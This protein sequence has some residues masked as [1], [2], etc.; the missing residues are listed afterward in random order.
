MKQERVYTSPELLKPFDFG[1]PTSVARIY[2]YL[3]SYGADGL[4]WYQDVTVLSH[5]ANVA[6]FAAQIGTK[7]KVDVHKVWLMGWLR[8]IGRVSWGIAAN[9][10]LNDITDKYGNHGFLG[11]DFLIRSG[12]PEELAVIA[13]TH[14]GS[15]VT[16]QEVAVINKILGKDVFPAR[17]WFATTLEEKI[18]VIAD[19]IPRWENTIIT[20]YQANQRGEVKGNKIYSWLENQTPLWERFWRFKAEVDQACGGDVLT[21]FDKGLLVSDPSSY[22]RMPKPEEIAGMNY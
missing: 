6:L 17:D 12:V 5:I 7:A 15:G 2:D 19:K 4:P 16:A 11:Y 13:M 8:D 3:L 21:F 20:P 10:K 9:Q 1:S 18:V 22:A 14:I